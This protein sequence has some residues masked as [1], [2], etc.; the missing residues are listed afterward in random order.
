MLKRLTPGVLALAGL[1]VLANDPVTAQDIHYTTV[2]KAEFGGSLGRMMKLTGSA[3]PTTEVTYIK[4]NRLRTDAGEKSSTITD[5]GDG[6]LTWLNHD[7]KTFYSMSI[8]DMTA[9]AQQLAA[10]Y[11]SDS[12]EPNQASQDEPQVTYDIKLS[13]DKTGKKE[14]LHGSQ[15]EQIILTME[16]EATEV[17]EQ[18]DSALVGTMVVLTDLWMSTDF[19]AYEAM[20]RMEAEWGKQWQAKYA[21]ANT[22]GMDQATQTDPRIGAAMEKLGKELDNLEGIALKSTTHF[23][24]VPPGAKFDRKK[25]L[26][27]ADKNLA[28]D[29]AGAAA[30]EAVKSAEGAVSGIT[31]GMFGKSKPK[32]PKPEQSTVMRVTSEV[33][34]VETVLLQDEVFEVPPNYTE[35]KLEGNLD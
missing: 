5:F 24:L 19:P 15:V 12:L 14:K 22:G 13:T 34:E 29:A 21:G 4:G 35:V 23:V 9:V 3:D 17:A 32:E 2:S 18:E 10:G 1:A 16:I 7:S 26:K 6:V 8:A 11:T 25:A 20:Q 27:D 30:N 33:T 31:G 28:D